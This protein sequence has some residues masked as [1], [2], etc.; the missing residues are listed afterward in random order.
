MSNLIKREKGFTL[1]EIVLVLAIAGL[2]LVIVF[3]ALQGAQKNRRDTAR[4]T[5][6]GQI[7]AAME[8]CASNG[9]NNGQYP[10]C[11]GASIAT[12]F[13]G[14][15]PSGVAYSAQAAG[16]AGNTLTKGQYVADSPSVCGGAASGNASVTIYQESGTGTQ[17]YCVH[18]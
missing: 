4:K 13:T 6:A 5:A 11:T 18:N 1:I 9:A 16:T 3:L 12:Y 8:S 7:L 14:T 15:D 17:A 2:L 10:N